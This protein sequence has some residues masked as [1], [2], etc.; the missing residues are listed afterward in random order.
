MTGLAAVVLMA[1]GVAAGVVRLLPWLLAPEVPFEVALPFA[2]ALGA[3]TTETVVLTALPIGF[4]LAAAA[5]NS[6]GE[7][8][9][10]AALGMSPARLTASTWLSVC[11]IAIVTYAG[12]MAWGSSADVPGQFAAQL[13]RQGRA[14]CARANRPRSA[15]VP[16]V[17][18]TWLCFPN[19]A[20]RVTGPLPGSASRAWFSA[21]NLVPSDDLREVSLT[22]LRI[23][24]RVGD[25]E[26]R[27]DLRVREGTVRGLP[28][29]GRSAKLRPAVRGALASATGLLLALVATFAVLLLGVERR[30]T[31]LALGGAPAVLA[32]FVLHR[33]DASN[34]QTHS[35]AL[36]PALGMTA[37]LLGL[38]AG[39]RVARRF[40]G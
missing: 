1:L 37:L 39:R 38:L 15:S 35:Y 40:A 3:A 24:T 31:A 4:A 25:G 19:A 16:L 21:S 33:L 30:W 8:R 14:S 23:V 11:L 17:G 28:A 18:V 2:R 36:V 26:K 5:F 27:L 9:A 22:D 34:A 6:R 13:V 32:L 12:G 29:W 10:L 20:P 7:T